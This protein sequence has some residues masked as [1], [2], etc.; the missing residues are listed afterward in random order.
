MYPVFFQIVVSIY[1]YEHTWLLIYIYVK[2]L[3][4]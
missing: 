3:A 1:I 4:Y 2:L